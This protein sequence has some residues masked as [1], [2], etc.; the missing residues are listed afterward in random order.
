MAAGRSAGY[1]ASRASGGA[2]VSSDRQLL[3]SAGGSS[4]P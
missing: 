2:R 4:L 1:A 3:R